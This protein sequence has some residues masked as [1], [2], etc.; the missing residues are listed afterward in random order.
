MSNN[1]AEN[2]IL[3]RVMSSQQD[4]LA[5][6]L[7]PYEIV[8][9]L[10]RGLSPREREVISM[11]FGLGKQGDPMTLEAIGQQYKITRERVRQIEASALRKMRQAD[12]QEGLIGPLGVVSQ[13]ILES[14]GGL[15]PDD[16]CM[17]QLLG[18]QSTIREQRAAALLLLDKLVDEVEHIRYNDDLEPSWRLKSTPWPFVEKTLAALHE[19]IASLGEPH[20]FDEVLGAVKEH[21]HYHEEEDTDA[22]K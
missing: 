3:Y 7:N 14:H 1:Q 9:K 6:D 21:A 20:V 5:K 16:M 8:I 10:G 12:E 13:R 22:L 2:S 17:N 11:R 15:M 19:V 4:S 18:Q